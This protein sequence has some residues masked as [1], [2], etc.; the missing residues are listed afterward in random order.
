[1]VHF[2]L[3]KH[4]HLHFPRIFTCLPHVRHTDMSQKHSESQNGSF[5][6]YCLDKWA[7]SSKP[8][9]PA[10]EILQ[11]SLVERAGDTSNF[12]KQCEMKR[13]LSWGLQDLRSSPG[14]LAILYVISG[15]HFTSLSPDSSPVCEAGVTPLPY[16]LNEV[17]MR[18]KRPQMGQ[19]V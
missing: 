14:I 7:S 12:L 6:V 1:M 8:S 15:A 16:S 17:L 13:T 2:V 10:Q 19:A 5:S 9:T 18:S 3:I 4:T 11:R